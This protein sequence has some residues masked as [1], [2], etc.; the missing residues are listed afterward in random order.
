MWGLISIILVWKGLKRD[1]PAIV[2][3]AGVFAIAS[4][5]SWIF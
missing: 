3:A 4:V 2:F 5:L 1:E